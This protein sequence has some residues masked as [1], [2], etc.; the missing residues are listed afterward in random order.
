[1]TH[2]KILKFAAVCFSITLFGFFACQPANKR[3]FVDN[4]FAYEDIP[5]GFDHPAEENVLVGFIDRDNRKAM[6]EHAWNLWA[7]ITAPSKSTAGNQNIPIF[8]T[9]YSAIEV[10]DDNYQNSNLHQEN[11]SLKHKFEVP[12]QSIHMRSLTGDGRI[13]PVMSFVKYNQAAANFIWENNYYLK[14]TLVELNDSFNKNNIPRE[15]REIKPFPRT[16]VVLKVVFWLVKNSTS[17]QSE[18]GLT[19][20]PYWD[21]NYPPPPDGQLPTH[22]TWT[23]CVAIDPAGKYPANSKQ[24]VNCNGTKE[25]PRFVE[26]EVLGLNRFYSYRL[27]SGEDVEDAANFL[28]MVSGASGKEERLVSNTGQ[29]PEMSDYI[30]LTAMHVTTKEMDNWT[31]QTFW[32]SPDPDAFPHGDFRTS[33][34]KGEWKN[35]QMCTAYDMVTP[36]MP[37]GFPN[38]C[39]N[40]YLETDLGPTKPYVVGTKSY[41]ADPLAGTET[42]CMNCHARAGFPAFDKDNPASANFGRVFN[43]GFISPDDPIFSEITKTDFLWS[44]PLHSQPQDKK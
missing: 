12:R 26:A 20:V 9:W 23:K 19:S 36:K 13:A 37:D 15:R 28:K 8:E 5:P 38:I 25:N 1:M 43:E 21:P 31:F 29:T 22:D 4:N 24:T 30:I 2:L 34:I 35:Y 44:I 41:P 33:N 18:N 32:W 16:A 27:N 11:R 39:F 3:T 10:F 40:P 14:S 42:N 17:P 6:R 7:G